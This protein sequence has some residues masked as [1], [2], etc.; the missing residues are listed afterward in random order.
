MI[1]SPTVRTGFSALIAPWNTTEASAQRTARM[2]PQFAWSRSSP[3]NLI[4]P[5]TFVSRGS[6]RSRLIATVVLP[7]PDSPAMPRVSPAASER[8]TPRAAYTGTLPER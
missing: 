8:S 1:W 2:R 3:R 5:V 6:S 4:S 7:D